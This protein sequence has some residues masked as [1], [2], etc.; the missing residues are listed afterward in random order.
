MRIRLKRAYP[1]PPLYLVGKTSRYSGLP[2][3]TNVC[4]GIVLPHLRQ[5]HIFCH[6]LREDLA[7][8]ACMILRSAHVSSTIWRLFFSAAWIWMQSPACQTD[9]PMFPTI[10][11]RTATSAHTLTGFGSLPPECPGFFAVEERVPCCFPLLYFQGIPVP[12][13]GQPG[14]PRDFRSYTQGCPLCKGRHLSRTSCGSLFSGHYC[15]LI[16]A[17]SGGPVTIFPQ[18]WCIAKSRNAKYA[19]KKAPPWVLS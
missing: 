9:V 18:Q 15:W 14:N 7:P 5:L 3:I 13:Q 6:G 10:M 4:H 19:I 1:K 2:S 8:H 16:L 17:S 11:V 12:W